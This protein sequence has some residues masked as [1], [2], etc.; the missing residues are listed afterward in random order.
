MNENNLPAVLCQLGIFNFPLQL[1]HRGNAR[2][3]LELWKPTFCSLT[4]H[5]YQTSTLLD[6]FPYK[7]VQCCIVAS[8]RIPS[9]YLQKYRP[10]TAVLVELELPQHLTPWNFFRWQLTSM[11]KNT[12]CWGLSELFHIL[13]LCVRLHKAAEEA[14]HS[15]VLI[16]KAA[17]NGQNLFLISTTE[18]AILEFFQLRYV[19]ISGKISP[20]WLLIQD[21][22]NALQRLSRLAAEAQS[23]IE[24][25]EGNR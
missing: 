24:E 19:R 5:L 20:L 3:I 18:T 22:V 16:A 25:D 10:M 23:V 7:T 13:E 21:S 6:C 12:T 9:K 11:W 2:L 1:M 17:E 14:L 4:S 8:F 15:L